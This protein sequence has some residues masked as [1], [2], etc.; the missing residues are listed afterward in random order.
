[1]ILT[2]EDAS[3]K[4]IETKRNKLFQRRRHWFENRNKIFSIT[5]F[6]FF[7]GILIGNH[8]KILFLNVQSL[9]NHHDQLKVLFAT[10]PLVIALVVKPGELNFTH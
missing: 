7:R 4:K 2:E 5:S 1:M 9:R 10:Q 8:I 3:I 6:V